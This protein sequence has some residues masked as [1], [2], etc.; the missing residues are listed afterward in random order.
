MK[1]FLLSSGKISGGM[2][3]DRFLEQ[4]KDYAS[5]GRMKVA[6]ISNRL[7]ADLH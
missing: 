3:H 4:N 6:S 2:S 5:F 1:V 7:D